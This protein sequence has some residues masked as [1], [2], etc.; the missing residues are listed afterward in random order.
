MV[1]KSQV[2]LKRESKVRKSVWVMCYYLIRKEKVKESNIF[3]RMHTQHPWEYTLMTLAIS[4]VNRALECERDLSNKT[5]L[6][7]LNS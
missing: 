3:A 6:D 4:I 1:M 5:F 2:Y 7:L